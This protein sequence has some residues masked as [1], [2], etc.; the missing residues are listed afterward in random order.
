M[1]KV[2]WGTSLVV[3]WL[4]LCALRVGSVPGGG[5]KIPHAVQWGQKKKDIDERTWRQHKQMERHIIFIV[6]RINT[7]KMT[8]LPKAI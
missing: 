2:S 8:V 1:K 5:T 4:R 3:E 7:V 6:G